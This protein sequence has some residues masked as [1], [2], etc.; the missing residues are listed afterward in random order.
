MRGTNAVGDPTHNCVVYDALIASARRL[1]LP[2][3]AL[4]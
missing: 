2:S 3:L 4:A 1:C